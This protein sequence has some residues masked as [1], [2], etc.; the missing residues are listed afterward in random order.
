MVPVEEGKRRGRGFGRKR[1]PFGFFLLIS[2]REGFGHDAED[3]RAVHEAPE[4][5]GMR[6]ARADHKVVDGVDAGGF[7]AGQ[8][9]DAE[10]RAGHILVGVVGDVMALFVLDGGT[11]GPSSLGAKVS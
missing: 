2:E 9:A 5:V 4:G 11:K 10:L 1:P 6:A 8:V 3:F 7:G